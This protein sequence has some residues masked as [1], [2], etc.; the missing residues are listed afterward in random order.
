MQTKF[1]DLHSLKRAL[2]GNKKVKDKVD[3]FVVSFHPLFFAFGIF[4]A[5]TGEIFVFL[6]YTFSAVLHEVG[7]SI[8]ASNRGYR[9]KKL[10]LMP[11]GATITGDFVDTSYKDEFF[12]AISGPATSLFIAIIFVASWWVFP[13]L[14]PY[15]ELAFT[16]NISLFVINLI[17]VFPLD[18]GR[19]LSVLLKVVFKKRVG[20]IALKI[21]GATLSTTTIAIFF[22]S[23]I[24]GNTL[25]LSLL[26]FGVFMLM[27]CFSQKVQSKYVRIYIG[28]SQN[29]LKR[30]VKINQLAFSHNSTIRDLSKKVDCKLLNQ[31]KIVYPN[32]QER[33]VS[34][35]QISYFLQNLPFNTT[36]NDALSKLP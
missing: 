4:Y 3:G 25:N 33:D 10:S 36:L 8:S 26:F 1:S 5:L 24:F 32:G 13:D 19:L 27:G 16:A 7:H 9:L 22:V 14:Y 29:L 17:P 11:Y 28:V 20:D 12:I 6:V 35:A 15:T 2:F 21:L 31:V 23:L 18:G 30:G 34:E